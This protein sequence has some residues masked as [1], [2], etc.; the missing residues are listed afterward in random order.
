MK[1]GSF[2]VA[3]LLGIL[4]S[5]ALAAPTDCPWHYFGGQAPDFLNERLSA[6]TEEICYEEFGLIHSGV[7]RTPLTSAE[8]LTRHELE[9]KHPRRQSAFHPDPNLPRSHRAELD[10]YA[11][12]GFDRG[13]MAP[14]GDMPDE[15]SQYESFSLANIVPQVP[16]NNQ[17][18]WE[19]IEVDTRKLAR[20]DGHLYIVTGPIFYGSRLKRIGGRVLVPTYLYKAI[21]D[22]ARNEA[23][24]YLVKNAEGNRYA[25]ISI[26]ELDQLS[27]IS[28]FP[29]L[30]E[31]VKRRAM[32]LP[33]PRP[34]SRVPAV[35]D[36]SI[37][38]GKG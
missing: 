1:A 10:D 15:K 26:A 11:R 30:P 14:S 13:H 27:G 25:V 34:H 12:S 2:I 18:L 24:A 31:A 36:Q 37:V 32:D 5:V 17:N 35:K 8:H 29:A 20:R 19:G 33:A 4:S 7:T 38:P 21:F 6:K 28:V 9:V 23:G 16:Q 22:P 3:L